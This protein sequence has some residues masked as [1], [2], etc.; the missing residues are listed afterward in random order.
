MW[1]GLN[2]RSWLRWLQG[3][4]QNLPHGNPVRVF[5][6]RSLCRATVEKHQFF[7]EGIKEQQLFLGEFIP[8]RKIE[9]AGGDF[10]HLSVMVRVGDRQAMGSADHG[11]GRVDKT[12]LP[13]EEGTTLAYLSLPADDPLMVSG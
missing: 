11:P 12:E 4:L 5:R 1:V 3:L 13:G 2:S 10:D 9:G 7:V 6:E 8:G